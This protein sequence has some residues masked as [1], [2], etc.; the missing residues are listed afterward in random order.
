MVRGNT[1]RI[2][3]QHV[4]LMAKPTTSSVLSSPIWSQSALLQASLGLLLCH[5][6]W[7][8]L[9]KEHTHSKCGVMH[10]NSSTNQANSYQILKFGTLNSLL[11]TTCVL[12]IPLQIS[13]QRGEHLG[14]LPCGA[15]SYS[16][17]ER[18]ASRGGCHVNGL[19]QCSYHLCLLAAVKDSYNTKDQADKWTA[20]V[21]TA[22]LNK[23]VLKL[24]CLSSWQTGGSVHLELVGT[25]PATP[26]DSHATV[27]AQPSRQRILALDSDFLPQTI[28]AGDFNHL[29]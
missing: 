9:A 20:S 7:R 27:T 4:S 26:S 19:Q 14:L 28:V 22:T 6:G 21:P 15:W 25:K 10:Y 17:I 13:Y 8:Q 5:Q 16:C 29:G 11:Y 23:L 12:C 2:K 3:M 1:S 18:S 24:A